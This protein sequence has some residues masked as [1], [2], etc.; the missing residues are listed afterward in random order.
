MN[1]I[2]RRQL[3]QLFFILIC[4]GSINARESTPG[5][6]GINGKWA[7]QGSI[8]NGTGSPYFMDEYKYSNIILERGRVFTK[9]KAR[10]D[11]ASLEVSFISVNGIEASIEAG[12]IK[13]ISFS[14]T[15]AE[16]IVLYKFKTG[17]PSI[18]KQTRNNFY[19]MLA[20][21][22]CSFLKAVMKKVTEKKNDISGEVVRDFETYEEF[23]IFSK[24][25]MKK[26]KKDKD[27]ILA[28]LSDRQPQVSQFIDANKITFRSEEQ[29][30]RLLNYYNSL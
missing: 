17:F 1:F 22:R 26:W 25:V 11:L 3:Q 29:L 27:F 13:E 28:E 20:D 23:Y 6:P 10:I 5:I 9:V 30:I 18:D 7:N 21:G 4:A 8:R 2:I 24:G 15:T 12:M 14:D 19:L 16:G